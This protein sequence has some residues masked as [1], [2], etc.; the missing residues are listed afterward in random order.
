MKT[1]YYLTAIILLTF[2]STIP[3]KEHKF[4]LELGNK[5]FSYYPKDLAKFL[6]KNPIILECGAHNGTDTAAMA[7]YWKNGFVYA[8]E[9]SPFTFTVLQKNTKG[10]KN[11]KLFPIALG[12]ENGYAEFHVSKHPNF[13]HKGQCSLLPSNH[14]EHQPGNLYVFDEIVTVPVM[15]LDAWAQKNSIPRIDFMWLDMQGADFNMLMASSEVLKTTKLIKVEISTKDYYKGTVL[16]DEGR[17]FLE[18]QGFTL[19][20][21][22]NKP[23]GDAVFIKT[24]WLEKL[25]AKGIL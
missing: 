17:S 19:L 14:D 12:W 21:D 6:P 22:T 8:I 4:P 7:R 2:P 10:L 11:V 13:P 16:Y 3:A 15:T 23:H 9:A 25:I 18:S 1:F 24:S 20:V 5:N